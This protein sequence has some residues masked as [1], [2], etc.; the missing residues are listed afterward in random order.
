MTVTSPPEFGGPAGHWSPET[1]LMGAVADCL[2]LTFRGIA[3]V[4]KLP[5]VSVRCRAEGV[6]E[7]KERVTMFTA[8]HVTASVVVEDSSVETEA[9]EM[10][11]RAEASCLITRSLNATVTFSP[12]VHLAEIPSASEDEASCGRSQGD[13]FIAHTAP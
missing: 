13:P 3:A 12:E 1:L 8:I 4:R 5:Y 7:R 10:L 6:L 11:E 9:R 2:V